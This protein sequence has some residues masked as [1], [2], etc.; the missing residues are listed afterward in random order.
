MSGAGSVKGRRK[1]VAAIVKSKT[2]EKK[3]VLKEESA[4]MGKDGAAGRGE[5]PVAGSSVPTAVSLDYDMPNRRLRIN[6]VQL[7]MAL[8]PSEM[9]EVRRVGTLKSK[10]MTDEPKL[11]SEV[12]KP[13]RKGKRTSF[14]ARY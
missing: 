7:R 12:R 9:V 14:S 8:R 6:E 1:G 10:A 13:H 2:P 5:M 3:V 11:G 4:S